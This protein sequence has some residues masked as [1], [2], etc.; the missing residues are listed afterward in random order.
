[1]TSDRPTKPQ[2][3]ATAGLGG[4]TGGTDGSYVATTNGV[5][6]RVTPEYAADRSKPERNQYFWLYTVEVRNGGVQA[7]QLVSR[8]WQITDALGRVQEVRGDGVVGKQ[9]K[10][11]PGESFEYTS[12]AMLKTPFG[13][14]R[15]AYFFAR[16]DGKTFE[17]KIGEFALVQPNS[18]H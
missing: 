17:G 9:P 13:T 2:S 15:G 16:P 5:E 18:L 8:H 3:G 1:M 4:G 10:L 12:W 14:M 6:V 7:L 11:G